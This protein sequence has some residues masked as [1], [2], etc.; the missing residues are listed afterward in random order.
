MTRSNDY[1]TLVQKLMGAE[2]DIE[3]CKGLITN[4]PPNEINE[5]DANGRTLL[6]LAV[7]R[8]HAAVCRLLI[9]QG[10]DI[11]EK[12]KTGETLPHLSIMEGY[13][14]G[15]AL[16]HLAVRKGHAAVCLLLIEQGAD[17]NEKTKEG[18]TALHL[19]VKKGNKEICNLLIEK[20]A[21]INKKNNKGET[22]LH[23]AADKYYS[24][25]TRN[26]YTYLCKLLLIKGANYHATDNNGCTPFGIACKYQP[27][28]TSQEGIKYLQWLLN[29]ERLDTAIVLSSSENIRVGMNSKAGHLPQGLISAIC[30]TIYGASPYTKNTQRSVPPSL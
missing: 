6:H 2:I 8:G 5:I 13:K 30:Y 1:N 9:G 23:L 17:I 22:A 24:V 3:K 15:D 19:A 7:R 10:A 18:E 4:L 12:T 16:L 28:E 11:N 26:T 14:E 25:S 27:Q 20:G 21:D 29:P